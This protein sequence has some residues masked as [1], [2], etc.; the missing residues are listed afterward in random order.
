MYEYVSEEC[1]GRPLPGVYWAMETLLDHLRGVLERHAVAVGEAVADLAQLELDDVPHHLFGDG[2]EGHDLH[3]G[4]ECRLEVIA[5]H[6]ADRLHE[7]LR[8]RPFI[9]FAHGGD[10]VGGEIAGQKADGV[11][12]IDHAAFAV[13]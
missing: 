9:A 4:E 5:E 11:L 13:G 1:D 10:D 6:G 8:L 7:L 2:I 3:A 12:E